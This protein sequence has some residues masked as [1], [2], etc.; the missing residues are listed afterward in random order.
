MNIFTPFTIFLLFIIFG[1]MNDIDTEYEGSIDATTPNK[2]EFDPNII[3]VNEIKDEP[4]YPYR[5]RIGRK[6]P[7]NLATR[8]QP[9][10]YD[11]V[12]YLKDEGTNNMQKLFGRETY[13]GS[14]SWNYFAMSDDYHQ[15]AIPLNVGDKDCTK[16]NGCKEINDKEILTIDGKETKATIYE[17]NP[18][19][20]SP[21]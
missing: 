8:G 18:Y 11:T 5:Q 13:P 7:M 1:L 17:I 10:D 15:I 4:E 20:Y 19:R 12:G 21:Y 6:M 2:V 16:E 3:I 14:N 9:R